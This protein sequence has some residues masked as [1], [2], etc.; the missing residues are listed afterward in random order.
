MVQDK[1]SLVSF[2]E[3][4]ATHCSLCVYLRCKIHIRS[5]LFVELSWQM[6]DWLVDE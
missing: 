4:G 5:V 6:I 1:I 2:V 3:W